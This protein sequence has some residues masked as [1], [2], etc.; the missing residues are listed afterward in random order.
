MVLVLDR[1]RGGLIVSCQ[2]VDD[3][4]MDRVDII[5]AMAM[6]AVAGGA[7]G[8]R[9]EGTDNLAA[10]R[11]VV[12]VPLIGI[13]KRDLADSPVRIT[14]LEEDVDALVEGG[15]DIVAYDATSRPRP[16]P[17]RTICERIL[18]QDVLAMADCA[19]PDDGRSALAQGAQILGS[20]LSGYTAETQDRNNGPDFQLVREFAALGG[21]VM[22]E[23]RINTPALA[24]QAIQAGASAVTVGSAVTRIEHIAGWY[25]SAVDAGW[26][27]RAGSL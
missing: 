21:F 24:E 16:V 12:S 4:P 10:V 5:V 3:G 1:L 19:T 6:A 22:A 20:T 18:S 17:A 26:Q 7:V 27:A 9:I 15:A 11:R 23:G 2:P 25:R 13:V 14:T 8:L